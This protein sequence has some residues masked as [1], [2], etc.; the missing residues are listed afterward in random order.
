MGQARSD[1]V[2]DVH[3]HL[4]H[5]MRALPGCMRAAGVPAVELGGMLT[6][7]GA[8]DTARRLARPGARPYGF[9]DL[10]QAGRLDLSVEALVVTDRFHSL[11]TAREV[12]YCELRLE[13]FDVAAPP[14]P[15]WG[16]LRHD[17][18]WLR[19]VSWALHVHDQRA[20]PWPH[21]EL[22]AGFR[23]LVAD[24]HP[25]G[26]SVTGRDRHR[27][28]QQR[29]RPGPLGEAFRASEHILRSAGVGFQVWQSI[30]Y[31]ARRP[32]AKGMAPWLR[33]LR[34]ST[35]SCA[36]VRWLASARPSPS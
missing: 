10:H 20:E 4:E 15:Q 18:P 29:A 2:G 26:L 31:N 11:F 36:Q 22:D 17:C 12:A 27:L 24:E 3:R 5:V 23:F 9:L 8:F 1:R 16:Q 32:A 28:R 21:R 6:T 19:S 35:R 25:G 30:E 34:I 33:L 14:E 13:A 7:H